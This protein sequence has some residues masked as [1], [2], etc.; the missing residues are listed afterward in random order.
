ML[1]RLTRY[2]V[3]QDAGREKPLYAGES[4]ELPDN[5]AASLIA[6]GRAVRVHLAVPEAKPMAPPEIKRRVRA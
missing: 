5:I 2:C 6:T 1:I 3:F 4:H